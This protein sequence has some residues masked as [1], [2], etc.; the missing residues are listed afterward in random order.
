[1]INNGHFGRTRCKRKMI[2]KCILLKQFVVDFKLAQS[3]GKS[4]TF[5]IADCMQDTTVT[6][7]SSF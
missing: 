3:G 6:S 1:M 7:L 2:L 4:Q 5:Q